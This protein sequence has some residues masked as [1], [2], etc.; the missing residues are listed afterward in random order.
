MSSV[1][2]RKGLNPQHRSRQFLAAVTSLLMPFTSPTDPVVHHGGLTESVISY[3]EIISD[4][5]DFI[6]CANR[7]SFC[8]SSHIHM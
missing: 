4:K 7:E 5:L 3:H 2:D 8:K 6:S 1:R